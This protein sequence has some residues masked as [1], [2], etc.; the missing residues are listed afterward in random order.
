MNNNFNNFENTVND[1]YQRFAQ[2]AQNERQAQDLD[3]KPEPVQVQ[4][5]A[6]RSIPII[7]PIIAFIFGK[8]Q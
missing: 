1:R 6:M 4:K 7:T 3:D 5:F 8:L 2:Q